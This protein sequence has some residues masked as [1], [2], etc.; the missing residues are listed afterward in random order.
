MRAYLT[1][2]MLLFIPTA[3]GQEAV[4]F[5]PEVRGYVHAGQPSGT[6]IKM[7]HLWIDPSRMDD[8]NNSGQMTG[9]P[10]GF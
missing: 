8:K 4:A 1:K 9:V 5:W 7:E 3:F 10:G 2:R 6:H